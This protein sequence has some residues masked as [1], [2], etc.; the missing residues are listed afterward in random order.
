MSGFNR[1]IVV[2]ACCALFGPFVHLQAQTK[3][4][5]VFLAEGRVHEAKKEW[6]AALECYRK[7]ADEDPTDPVYQVAVDKG[8]LQAAQAHV[9]KGLTIRSQGRLGDALVEFQK[10]YAINPGSV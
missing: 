10:A 5:D 3:K 4:G 6:D 2:A 7:A 1:L 9:E 8:R